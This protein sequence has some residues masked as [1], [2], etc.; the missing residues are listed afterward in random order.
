[1]RRR[2]ATIALVLLGAAVW[3]CAPG[4][5]L[6]P[7]SPL[8][9]KTKSPHAHTAVE[10]PAIAPRVDLELSTILNER[11]FRTPGCGQYAREL[12]LPERRE[13]PE[14]QQ[15]DVREVL[16]V[17][18]ERIAERVQVGAVPPPEE[19]DVFAV[20]G[21]IAE[22]RRQWRAMSTERHATIL[23]GGE[24]PFAADLA[25][26][27]A[28]DAEAYAELVASIGEEQ[29]MHLWFETRSVCVLELHD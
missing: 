24:D 10:A 20:D 25:F 13:I 2:D 15:D 28:A 1:V 26:I 17:L 23:R 16:E 22:L 9:E 6:T 19:A 14:A 3:K 11:V 27:A 5:R 4:T 8:R 29:A 7:T 12:T 18:R 21:A